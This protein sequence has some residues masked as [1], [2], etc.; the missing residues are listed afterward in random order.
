MDMEE[1]EKRIRQ[2]EELFDELKEQHD[3]T[4]KPFQIIKGT[5]PVLLSAPHSTTQLRNGKIKAKEL[6]TGSIIIEVAKQTNCYAIYKLWNNQDDAN[7]DIDNNDYKEQVLKLIQ[8]NQI[9]LFIDI[10]GSNNTDRFDIDI[11]TDN[12]KNLNGKDTL[13]NNWIEICQKKGIHK[14]GIDQKF[15]ANTLHTITKTVAINYPIP[16]MQMEITRE[17]RDLKNFKHMKLIIECLEEFI[18][19]FKNVHK[20]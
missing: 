14:V 9:Q 8:E 13:L 12:L 15:K 5:C 10:H 7:Y 17:Y 3:K 19:P 4:Q 2:N 11:G 1:I 18:E 6:G 20:I 16:C